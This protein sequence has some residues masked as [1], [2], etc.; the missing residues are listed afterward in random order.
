MPPIFGVQRAWIAAAAWVTA[1][2][3]VATV[4][5]PLVFKSDAGMLVL[6]GGSSATPSDASGGYADSCADNV[7]TGKALVGDPCAVDTDC[8]SCRCANGV[9]CT[10]ACTSSQSCGAN[11][12]GVPNV[13]AMAT[14]G[15]TVCYPGCSPTA[16]C[17]DF[18]GTTCQQLPSGGVVCSP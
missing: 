18:P 14:T 8:A 11:G 1:G 10:A 2:C 6:D 12:A 15:Q 17:Q 13:C 9:W 3:T 16:T 5:G 4:G 7:D